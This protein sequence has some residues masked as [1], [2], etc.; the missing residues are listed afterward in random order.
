[1]KHQQAQQ[2]IDQTWDKT[3]VPTVE[4]Y[5]RIPNKSPMF[6]ADWEK[7]GYMDQA[8]ELLVNWANQQNING[9]TLQVERMPGKTPL[10]FIEIPG[11]KD[12]TVL[13]YGHCDKQPEMV[14]WDDDKGPWKPVRVGEKLYGRGGADD[15]YAIFAALT[16]IKA[17]QEQNIPHARCVVLIEASEESGS[18]DLPEYVDHLKDKI[19]EPN[20]II[21]LDS[22]AG[23]YEQL[24]CTTSLRGVINGVLSVDILTEGVHS[25]AASGA[26]ASSF[27]ILRELL[28]R[29]DNQN[30]G[31]VLIKALQVDIP[32]ERIEEAKHVAKALGE[33][34]WTEYPFVE[35]A[36]PVCKDN[37]ENVLNRTWRAAL[38]IT[39]IDGVPALA[40][41]GNVLR[42]KTV[43]LLSMRTPPICDMQKAANALKETLEKNPPY[44]AKV[45]YEIG[46][47][48]EGWNAPAVAPWLAKAVE[49][50]SQTYFDKPGLYWGEGGS[51]PFM[52][53]LGE[54]FPKAQFMITGV[55][56][57]HSN[58]HGPNEF[59]HIE[60][61]KKVTCCV[62]SVLA[63]HFLI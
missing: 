34:V 5:I 24:W 33:Q 28:S 40:D 63:E 31:E 60:Y 38:S 21:C 11:Q 12:E 16:A 18:R 7:H 46:D 54:K 45:N 1:M 41:A 53:M 25:G 29:V 50:A 17:L 49:N 27:R 10:I 30:T 57:P 36:K 62:A 14:G 44:N 19:G 56:G 43:A 13:L 23:N 39:G 20:L 2:L 3:I 58:A 52:G 35:S 48:G 55:L 37:I 42:P 32:K 51:I 9:M 4:D 47:V 6:D 26:V 61:A 8:V 22:G 59:L 15:G